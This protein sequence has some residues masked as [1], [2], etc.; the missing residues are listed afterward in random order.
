MK[1]DPLLDLWAV[2]L[3]NMQPLVSRLSPLAMSGISPSP[4]RGVQGI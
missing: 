4:D 1:I 3:A 2:F